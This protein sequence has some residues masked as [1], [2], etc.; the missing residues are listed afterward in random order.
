MSAIG[1]EKYIGIVEKILQEKSARGYDKY[2]GNI[3]R[4][5]KEKKCL[6]LVKMHWKY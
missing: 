2:I 6:R 1:W 5:L 3:E 4:I